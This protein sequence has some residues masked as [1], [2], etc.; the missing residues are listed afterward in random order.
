LAKKTFAAKK[1]GRTNV[2]TE[3]T[4]PGKISDRT[5]GMR[6]AGKIFGQ[7]A[8]S[9]GRMPKKRAFSGFR[10][11]QLEIFWRESSY[12]CKNHK[13]LA[14]LPQDP[15]NPAATMIDTTANAT[16]RGDCVGAFSGVVTLTKNVRE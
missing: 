15:G 6:S 9:V 12:K 3:K 10:S 14:R 7:R 13:I 5:S 1:S 8:R 2:R 16:G 4:W 11:D